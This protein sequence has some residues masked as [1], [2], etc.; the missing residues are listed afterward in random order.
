MKQYTF[1]YSADPTQTISKKLVPD[2]AKHLLMEAALPSK[3]DSVP[4]MFKER[5]LY[6]TNK[7]AQV[8]APVEE[9]EFLGTLQKQNQVTTVES[10]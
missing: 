6:R 9:E 2:E 8:K 3:G 7:L 5:T 1:L 10:L 4:Q